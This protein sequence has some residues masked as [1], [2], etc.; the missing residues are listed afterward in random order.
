MSA[1]VPLGAD[2][3]PAD[4]SLGLAACLSAY[5]DCVVRSAHLDPIVTEMVRLRCARTHNCRICSTLRLQDA[6]DAGISDEMTNAIDWYESSELPERIKVALRIVDCFV[7][8]P[9][10]LDAGLISQAR[11]HFSSAELAELCVDIT[12]WSTQKIHVA[13]GTDGAER[14][15]TDAAGLAYFTFT[16][17]GSAQHLS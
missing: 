17:E 3:R 9:L 6:I 14:L 8:R 1:R 12:K 5:Q 4:R 15:N 13:Q 10:D 11:E 2:G 16:S 7:W